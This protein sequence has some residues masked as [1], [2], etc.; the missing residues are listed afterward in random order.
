MLLLQALLIVLLDIHSFH[1]L[2]DLPFA[3]KYVKKY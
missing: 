2:I 1:A 3:K